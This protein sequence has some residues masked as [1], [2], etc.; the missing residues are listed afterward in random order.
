LIFLAKQDVQQIGVGSRGEIAHP[1][2]DLLQI[3]NKRNDDIRRSDGGKNQGQA[4][5]RHPAIA[6]QHHQIFAAGF[7]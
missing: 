3:G 7:G 5:R 6:A 4:G 2:F 1:R